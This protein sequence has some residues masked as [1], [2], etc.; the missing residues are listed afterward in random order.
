MKIAR[1]IP[2]LLLGGAICVALIAMPIISTLNTKNVEASGAGPANCNVTA[3]ENL[4]LISDASQYE[5]EF[6]RLLNQG[7][8]VVSLETLNDANNSAIKL[9]KYSA[10]S[11]VFDFYSNLVSNSQY[12]LTD[13]L[14]NKI[15]ATGAIV[16]YSDSDVSIVDIYNAWRQ[17]DAL[18]ILYNGI[19]GS[20][21]WTAN[22]ALSAGPDAPRSVF[23]MT[24]ICSASRIDPTFRVDYINGNNPFATQVPDSGMTMPIHTKEEAAQICFERYGIDGE[25]TLEDDGKVLCSGLS[26][27]E[28]EA[29]DGGGVD[30]YIPDISWGPNDASSDEY[31]KECSA[32]GNL[33]ELRDGRYKC[34]SDLGSFPFSKE[35][36]DRVCK[37]MNSIVY[38]GDGTYSC[39]GIL[40]GNT[41]SSG[42]SHPIS[43]D[44]SWGGSSSATEQLRQLTNQLRELIEQIKSDPVYKYYSELIEAVKAAEDLLASI[45]VSANVRDVPVPEQKPDQPYAVNALAARQANATLTTA[46]QQ[47]IAAAVKRIGDAMR[48]LGIDINLGQGSSAPTVEDLRTAI[49]AAKNV[50]KYPEYE[51]L[52]RALEAAEYAMFNNTQTTVTLATLQNALSSTKANITTD[53]PNTG[54]ST[55]TDG[56]TPSFI[57]A[58][59]VSVLALSIGSFFVTRRILARR[60]ELL[61]KK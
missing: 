13:E 33:V 41:T 52:A 31:L 40:M 55:T 25:I 42:G 6:D 60:S 20:V 15:A 47:D 10:Y 59:I 30:I 58:L 28:W 22:T 57:V 21:N 2:G 26:L 49:K 16:S 50:A 23:F 46:N 17:Q 5:A 12:G 37:K 35:E 48:N 34:S 9:S 38:N 44:T 45:G 18:E 3:F 39:Y 7:G 32:N 61:I 54:S 51:A 27:G 43:P 19:Y 14:K 24:T 4:G 36:I 56:M 53:A 11:Q 29:N 8:L 1:K